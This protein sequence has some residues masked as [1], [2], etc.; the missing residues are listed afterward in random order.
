MNKRFVY[1]VGNNKKVTLWCTA[2][3]IS[4]F[5]SFMSVCWD[6]VEQDVITHDAFFIM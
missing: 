6:F 2:N 1:Q 5:T 4:R 3:Q